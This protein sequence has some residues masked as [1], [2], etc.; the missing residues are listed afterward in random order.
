MLM[1][2]SISSKVKIIMKNKRPSINPNSFLLKIYNILNKEGYEN[3]IGWVNDGNA[4]EIMNLPIFISEILPEYFKHSNLSSF[5]RQLNMY[6]FH[7]LPGEGYFFSH[8]LFKRNN[9][10]LLSQIHRKSAS[11]KVEKN[12]GDEI[13]YKIKKLRE[14]NEGLVATVEKLEYMYNELFSIN[15]VLISHLLKC[16]DREQYLEELLKLSMNYL[17]ENPTIKEKEWWLE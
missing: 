10:D 6:D 8:P 7:K 1:Q 13:I 2:K 11:V 16:Q 5:I 15:Q 12:P 17:K 9:E 14:N 4:F 3:V